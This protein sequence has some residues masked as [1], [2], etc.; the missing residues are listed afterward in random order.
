MTRNT[1]IP[2]IIKVKE[3]FI[4]IK[5][6]S[7]QVNNLKSKTFYFDEA[8]N[9]RELF[10]FLKKYTL[11]ILQNAKIHSSSTHSLH[12]EFIWSDGL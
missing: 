2:K 7:Y 4:R 12:I 1:S 8:K 5:F 10:L 6:I 9:I 3:F 11:S